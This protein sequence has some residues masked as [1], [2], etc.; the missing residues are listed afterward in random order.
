MLSTSRGGGLAYRGGGLTIT[1][2]SY[3]GPRGSRGRG[4]DI[5]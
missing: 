2:S 1:F 3:R 5:S 4:N